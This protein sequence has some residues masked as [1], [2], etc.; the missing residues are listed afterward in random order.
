MSRKRQALANIAELLDNGGQITIGAIVPVACA[1]VAIQERRTLAMLQRKRG[2]TL[3]AL[4]QRLDGAVGAAFETD[5]TI[6]EI[7]NSPR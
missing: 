1:A 5:E 4:L 6:D 2:E 3:D 7:N